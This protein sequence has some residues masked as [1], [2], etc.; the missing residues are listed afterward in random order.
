[1]PEQT[2]IER[3]LEMDL[4]YVLRGIQCHSL[5]ERICPPRPGLQVLEPGCGSGK[6]GIWYAARNAIVTLLDYDNDEL[7]YASKLGGLVTKALGREI[8]FSLR[9]GSIHNMPNGTE[10]FEWE[11]WTNRFDL[12]MNEGVPQHW[13]Y[14]PRDWRRQRALNEMV[15]VTKFGGTVC[16][17]ANNALCPAIMEMANRV[18]HTYKGMPK[19]EKP[20]T[21]EELAERLQKAGIKNPTVMQVDPGLLT[22]SRLIAGFGVKE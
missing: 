13:G 2:F 17:I 4:N 11:D 20:F 19:R 6:L 10:E 12:C 18:D 15:R 9:G 3:R 7:E 8:D 1:M 22:G 5:L 21:F 16:V 14:N